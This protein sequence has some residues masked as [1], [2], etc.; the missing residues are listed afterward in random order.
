M[1]D[2]PDGGGYAKLKAELIRVSAEPDSNR[3]NKFVG[4][5]EMGDKKTSQFNLHL[6]NLASPSTPEDLDRSRNRIRPRIRRVLTAVE[7]PNLV[8]FMRSS[9]LIAE[10]F[11]EDLQHIPRLA[12]TTDQTVMNET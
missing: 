6:K 8:K 2:R 5:E 7:D 3:V 1:T 12:T 9:D 10:E 11:G 4:S